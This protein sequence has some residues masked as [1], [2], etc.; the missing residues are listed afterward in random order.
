MSVVLYGDQRLLEYG[1]VMFVME[2]FF[3]NRIKNPIEN[4]LNCM[5]GQFLYL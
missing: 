1:I 3:Q 4:F 5:A 2:L